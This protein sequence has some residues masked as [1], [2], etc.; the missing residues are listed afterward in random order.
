MIPILKNLIDAHARLTVPASELSGGSN[1]FDLGLT[2][3]TAIRLMLA[4]EQ[5]FGMEFPRQMLSP[6]NVRS[7]D[8]ILGC[9]EQ[10]R[11]LRPAA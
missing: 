3:F 4:V 8:A 6:R 7:I 11:L 9:L 10:L 1:L 2:P 5:A